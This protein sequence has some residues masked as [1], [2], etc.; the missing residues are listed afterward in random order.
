[1][2]GQSSG[3]RPARGGVLAN[4]S[5]RKIAE[6]G[7]VSFGEFLEVRRVNLLTR[8]PG[9]SGKGESFSA[10]AG[11]RAASRFRFDRGLVL[12]VGLAVARSLGL[13][14]EPLSVQVRETSEFWVLPHT[15][16][17]VL[18]WNDQGNVRRAERFLRRFFH[19]RVRRFRQEGV[20][21]ED[22]ERG[23]MQEVSVPWHEP[24][25]E[26]RRGV[27]GRSREQVF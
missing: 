12:V 20:R 5:G 11:R 19:E 17:I 27:S 26:P 15:S 25:P 14:P 6:M 16:G 21:R 7:G 4:R 18:W 10:L 13:R 2:V 22:Q 9:Q 24:V 8:W 3:K 1:V 23:N